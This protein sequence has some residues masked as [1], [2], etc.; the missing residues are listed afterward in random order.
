MNIPNALH[1][2]R[3]A[4]TIEFMLIVCYTDSE[5]Q[6]FLNPPANAMQHFDAAYRD[7]CLCFKGS[8]HIR[9]FR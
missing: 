7:L 9:S 4:I 6:C 1:Q 5:V 2:F 3:L 8:L